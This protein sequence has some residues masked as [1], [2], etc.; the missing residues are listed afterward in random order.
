MYFSSLKNRR[1]MPWNVPFLL[2]VANSFGLSLRLMLPYVMN[3]VLRTIYLRIVINDDVTTATHEP[4][5]IDGLM[6]CKL[7][8]RMSVRVLN[9]ASVPNH[10]YV[11]ALMMDAPN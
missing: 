9:H 11:L 1:T 3:V 10:N 4:N 7:L 2:Q 6:L 8:I 5:L